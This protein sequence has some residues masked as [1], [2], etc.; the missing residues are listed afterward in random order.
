MVDEQPSSRKAFFKTAFSFFRKGL[1]HQI[2][3]KISRV[4]RFPIRPPGARAE[5]EFLSTCTR[6]D[7]CIKACGYQALQKMPVE[8]GLAANTPFVNPS[9][10]PCFMCPDFPCITACEPQ[11]LRMKPP[12]QIKLGTAKID[13]TA[14][15]TYQNKVCTLCYDAC[16][17]PEKAIIIGKDYHP[18]ILSPCTGCGLCQHHCPTTPPSIEVFSP[19]EMRLKES[20]EF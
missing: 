3:R 1:S 17:L 10:Q 11:A 14:C 13:T 2:D 19:D 4:L 8:S 6:C 9:I 7:A 15:I 16:P 12:D 18:E 5:I 20:D